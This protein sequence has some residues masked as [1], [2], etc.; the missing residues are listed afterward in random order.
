MSRG[1]IVRELVAAAR[2][3]RVEEEFVVAALF[4]V[5]AGVAC[6]EL[7]ASVRGSR[8][9]SQ[10]WR[11]A[12]KKKFVSEKPVSFYLSGRHSLLRI[13]GQTPS[14]KVDE[15][16]VIASFERCGPILRSWRSSLLS[17][18]ASTSVENYCAVGHR[19]LSTVT[20]VAT[21]RD[22]VFRSF[23]GFDHSLFSK[24]TEEEKGLKALP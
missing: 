1:R 10:V 19:R 21:G 18:L 4:E 5:R 15:E 8:R 11:N 17:S 7:L 6:R 24:L 14:Q 13:P 12:W 20:R 2:G 16:G 3:E 9:R 22:E 23:R